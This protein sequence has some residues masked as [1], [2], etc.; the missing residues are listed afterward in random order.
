MDRGE[1]APYNPYPL[2]VV[3]G[4]EDAHL[5]AMKGLS[6]KEKEGPSPNL[7]VMEGKRGTIPKFACNG[8][9]KRDHPQI[10]M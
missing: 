10:C 7:H 4:T 9:K 2:L 8:R 1:F 5:L 3:E 6:W